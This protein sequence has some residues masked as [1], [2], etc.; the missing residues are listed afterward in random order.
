[1]A[2]SVIPAVIDALVDLAR[3]VLTDV[4]VYDGFGLS[5]DPGDFLMIGVGDPDSSTLDKAASSAQGWTYANT[6][7][8]DEEGD[9]TCAALSWNGDADQKTARDSVFAITAALEDALRANPSLGLDNLLWTGYG[10]TSDLDQNQDGSGAM[11]LLVFTI[12]FKARI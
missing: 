7:T 2:T 5:E 8:R 12:H 9:V 4:S 10:P 11:A 1:M 3:D 6:T